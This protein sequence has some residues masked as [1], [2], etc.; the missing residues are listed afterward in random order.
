M[1]SPRMFG[2]S[3]AINRVHITQCL[4]RAFG[5]SEAINHVRHHSGA[6]PVRTR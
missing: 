1:C 2:E 6:R 5:E 4:P 3:E